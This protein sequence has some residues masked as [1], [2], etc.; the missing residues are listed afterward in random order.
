MKHDRTR[1][2]L[3]VGV[4]FAAVATPVNAQAP[5]DNTIYGCI[6]AKDV[7]RVVSA[8][9]A[10]GP[11]ETRINWAIAGPQGP[12]GPQGA[13]GPHGPV[14]PQGPQGAPGLNGIDGPMGPQG[15][16]GADGPMGP[17][18]AQGPAGAAAPSYAV[19]DSSDPPQKIGVM[20]GTT[21]LIHTGIRWARL[22]L[23]EAG[24]F[25]N[26]FVFYP[27]SDCSGPGNLASNTVD[28]LGIFGFSS[29]IGSTLYYTEE[30]AVTIRFRAV[31]FIGTSGERD[32][33]GDYIPPTCKL[34]DG[35]EY[36]GTPLRTFDL[37]TLGLKAPFRFVMQP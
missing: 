36:Y 13:V 14:G 31:S 6:N 2:T 8:S 11:R 26:G 24:F 33:N 15:P 10:C 1:L 3:A 19:V 37:S 22:P 21:V 34:L 35:Q 30:N 25:Q 28:Q 18:G 9:T 23:T 17:Q 27:T 16:E 5:P 20:V 7:L 32:A 4:L 12:A 29:L